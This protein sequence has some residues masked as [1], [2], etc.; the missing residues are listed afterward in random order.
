MGILKIRL[1]NLQIPVP[2]ENSDAEIASAERGDEAGNAMPWSTLDNI[3][4]ANRR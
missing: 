3:K 1:R 2:G 4:D